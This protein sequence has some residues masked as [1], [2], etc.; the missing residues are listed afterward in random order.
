MIRRAVRNTRRRFIFTCPPTV[1]ASAST[2]KVPLGWPMLIVDRVLAVFLS[3]SPTMVPGTRAAAPVQRL[4]LTWMALCAL[5]H[6]QAA[7]D[8]VYILAFTVVPLMVL[9][10]A[11][12][13]T[14]KK[15]GT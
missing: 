6:E 8:E 15:N 10:S 4:P 2:G 1:S 11:G 9:Y 12:G 13:L 5:E 3:T 7:G 14:M